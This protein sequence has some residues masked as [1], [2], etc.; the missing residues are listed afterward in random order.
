MTQT[1]KEQNKNLILNNLAKYIIDGKGNF[2]NLEKDYDDSDYIIWKNEV[3]DYEEISE[4]VAKAIVKDKGKWG[5]TTNKE[6]IDDI[7][8][9]I[10]L[11]K[12]N[13]EIVYDDSLFKLTGSLHEKFYKYLPTGETISA[14]TYEIFDFAQSHVIMGELGRRD[15]IWKDYD[16]WGHY[17]AKEWWGIRDW[18]KNKKLKT[19]HQ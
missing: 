10:L 4:K 3:K 13:W 11:E 14:Q 5:S 7:M 19:N 6:I 12:E 18:K 1:Q 17:Q 2:I 15:H 9:S 16:Q 8:E